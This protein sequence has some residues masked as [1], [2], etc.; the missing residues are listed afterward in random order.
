MLWK[1]EREGRIESEELKRQHSPD[2][3]S[4]RPMLTGRFLGPEGMGST[5]SPAMY[6][7]LLGATPK[8]R[9]ALAP[10]WCWI[11]PALHIDFWVSFLYLTWPNSQSSP[12]IPDQKTI[13]Y[14]LMRWPSNLTNISSFMK[15]FMFPLNCPMCFFFLLFFSISLTNCICGEGSESKHEFNISSLQDILWLA[16]NTYFNT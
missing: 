5:V 7:S 16:I 15:M 8:G 11:D 13:I 10:A 3:A 9:V 14:G 6:S 4:A 2:I 12:P 1:E